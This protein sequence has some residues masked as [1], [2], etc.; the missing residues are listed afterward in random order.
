MADRTH[1]T[2]SAYRDGCRC[3]DCRDWK[4]RSRTMV[5]VPCGHC[6]QPCTKAPEQVKRFAAVFCSY[7]CRAHAGWNR[8]T[9]SPLAYTECEGCG[10]MFCHDARTVR[11]RCSS[12]CFRRK[13]QPPRF[14]AGSCM[15][16][17]DSF[18]TDRLAGYNALN[19]YCSKRCSSK[20]AAARRRARKVG[21][22]VAPVYRR[23][24]FERDGWRCQICR[25]K[26]SQPNAVPHPRAATI[27]HIIPLAR[28]GTHEPANCQTACF[29]CNAL[30]SDTGMGDQLRLIG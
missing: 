24:I 25:R 13:A 22:F 5:Q 26:V 18:V 11:L 15:R 27:D 30:K 28:G 4:R 9:S 16:C 21:A 14:H 8:S 1:G 19:R 6:A 10:R 12:S 3:D 7:E 20:D 2:P 17:G 29:I 23:R